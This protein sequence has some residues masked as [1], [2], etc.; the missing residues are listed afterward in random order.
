MMPS[1]GSNVIPDSFTGAIVAI[2]GIRDAAVLLNGPT[3][4]KF[5]HG[6]VSENQMPRT[7]FLD[8]LYYSEKFYF[9]QPRVPVTF[10]DD[11]DYVF[12]ATD[13]LEKIL[14]VVAQKGHGL[15]GVINSPGAALIGDDLLRFIKNANLPV[16]CI[17][18]EN[19]GFSQPLTSG[20]QNTVMDVFTRI[21]PP[22]LP[23]EKGCVNLMGISIFHHHWQGNIAELTTLLQACGIRVN[24][25]ICAGCTLAELKNISSAQF[26]VVIH[27]EY[28]DALVLFMA[29]RFNMD[30]FIPPNGAPVGFKATES[31]ISGVCEKLDV[32]PA[33]A[34][35]LIKCARQK[36]HE[37]LNRFNALTGLPKGATFAVDGDASLA[38]P[39]ATWLY[40]YLGMVPVSIRIN[41]GMPE[42]MDKI[43]SFLQAIDCAGAWQAPMENE[44]PDVVFG[45]GAVIARLGLCGDPFTGIELSLPAG[46]YQHVIPKT[47]MGPQGSL[48]LIERII[49]GLAAC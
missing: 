46:T 41:T 49:N 8:P 9:G 19:T 5:Y 44:T 27:A 14:P 24:T 47:Y 32:S 6:A 28:A 17:A 38:L 3:G 30:S 22:E 42:S 37:A 15:I 11:Y 36:S 43:K 23:R 48:Y 40:E 25:T 16:P 39:L 12:G 18:V 7:D 29:E 21:S 4:C 10:L 13:K 1:D 45:S 26:N 31:W 35:K 20:F 33:P 34:M 2:E